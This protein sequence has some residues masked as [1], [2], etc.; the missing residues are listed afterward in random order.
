MFHGSC[1]DSWQH[2]LLSAGSAECAQQ[3]EQAWLA[4]LMFEASQPMQSTDSL[5]LQMLEPSIDS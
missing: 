3:L 2:N 4:K 5:S 1:A